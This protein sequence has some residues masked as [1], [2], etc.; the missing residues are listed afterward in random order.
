[1]TSELLSQTS[2]KSAATN[3]ANSPSD[4]NPRLAE[5]GQALA[6]KGATLLRN[7]GALPLNPAQPVAVFGRVQLDWISVGYGSGGDVNP[8]YTTNLLDSLTALGVPVDKEVANTYR[9][10]CAENPVDPGEEWGKWPLSFPEMPIEPSLIDVASQ[11]AETAIVVVGRAAGEDRDSLLEPGSYYLTDDEKTLLTR[12]NQTFARTVAIVVTGN[13]MDL[14]WAEEIGVDALLLAWAGGQEGGRSIARVLV[15]ELEPGGRLTDTIAYRY[16]DYPSS[17]N[18]GDLD[19]NVYAED[20]YVG[21]RYFETFAPQKVQ[22]P[23]GFGVGYSTHAFEA[24]KLTREPDAVVV[25]GV[26]TNTG[27]RPSSGVAQLYVRKPGALNGAPERELVGF[28]RSAT[29][30][31]GESE[32]FTIRVPLRNLAVYDDQPGRDTSF[33]WVIEEGEHAFFLGANVRDAQPAGTLTEEQL[34]LERLEQA[35]APVTPFERMT[36]RGGE[37]TLEPVPLSEVDL[38]SRIMDRM[39][40][41]RGTAREGATFRQVVAGEISVEDFAASLSLR[42]LADLTYGDVTMNSPLGAPGNAGALGG[43]TES[44]RSL[45]VPPAIT[46]DGPSG[47]RLNATATLLP[48]GTALA[49]SWDVDTVNEMALLHA[50]E[51]AS[52]GS[53]I[54]LSPGMNIHRDPLCGRNFEY[55]SEDPLISGVFAAAVVEG[56]QRGGRSACPKHYAAN[57]QETNRIYNDSIVSERALREVYLR[58]FEIVVREASPHFIMTSYNKINGVWGHYN[59]ELVET[60]LRGEW[61]YAGA[62]MTDWWM[63]MAPDPNFEGVY[64]SAYRVRSGVDVLMPGGDV[65]QGTTRE[66]SVFECLQAG[67]IRR[68]EAERCAINVLNFLKNRYKTLAMRPE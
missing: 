66:D 25:E 62:I 20:I 33:T 59:Y 47:L 12:V 17:D 60:I 55:F 5:L 38:A 40:E 44:L 61:G 67:T 11:R 41:K 8:P 9:A 6:A 24:V 51:M 58:G 22:Y 18:F 14:S 21:Y 4:L 46:T 10:W 45:G 16:E 1:M 64:D 63:R 23:F 31:P 39:P 32:A 34:I 37:L 19:A 48:C 7:E 56:V 29:L 30:Q 52:L 2:T 3:L 35:S 53:D 28:S 36:R 50:E 42:D 27:E 13:V 15:G 68:E 43:V 57:N 49:S 26:I 65:H 54:L